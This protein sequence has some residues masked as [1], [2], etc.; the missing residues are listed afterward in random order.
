MLNI[1][2]KGQKYYK[3]VVYKGDENSSI[4]AKYQ[5]NYLTVF[6][7]IY[8]QSSSQSK[9]KSVLFD[10]KA[11]ICFDGA[12]DK[13]TNFYVNNDKIITSDDDSD[14]DTVKYYIMDING[15]N[16]KS[17]SAVIIL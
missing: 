8:D 11:K 13:L 1:P 14:N 3:R 10:N 4:T 7:Y 17:F 9:N 15:S 16:K 12:D 6:D 2:G 5:N